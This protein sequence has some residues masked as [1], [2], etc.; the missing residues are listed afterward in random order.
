MSSIVQVRSIHLLKGTFIRFPLVIVLVR[1]P[2]KAPTA[3][4]HHMTVSSTLVPCFHSLDGLVKSFTL[5]FAYVKV[6]W[7]GYQGYLEIDTG[8]WRVN[9]ALCSF[10]PQEFERSLESALL[11][12]GNSLPSFFPR[13]F[14]PQ[15]HMNTRLRIQLLS[16]EKQTRDLSSTFGFVVHQKFLL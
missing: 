3:V 5:F 12:L 4:R 2:L 11:C 9:E 13:T 6:S 1:A 15:K 10:F 8:A 16:C 14:L 7:K